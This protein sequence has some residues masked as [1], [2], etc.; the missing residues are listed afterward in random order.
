M[1]ETT[2][3]PTPAEPGADAPCTGAS[4]PGAPAA[5][6]GVRAPGRPRSERAEKAIIDAVIDLLAEESGVAGV[7]I[8]AV[9]ARAGVGKTTIYRR[10]PNKEAL[11][12]HAL[13]TMKGPLPQPSGASVREDLLTLARGLRSERARKRIQCF[14]NVVGAA[15]KHPELY[16]R[17]RQDVIEPR[18]EVFR[19][20]LRRGV[21]TGEVRPD[22]DVEAAVAMLIGS[23]TGRFPTERQPDDF[24]DAVV[25][26]L[27]RGI[28]AGAS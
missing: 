2:Q 24:P 18:R 12:V 5:R 1:T 10:W 13:A 28:A 25:D 17:Y 20:V 7:S 21:R 4:G 16:D 9:A 22:V 27:L 3:H 8:E 11:I 14:W 23:L 15:E 6:D 19:D 26:T